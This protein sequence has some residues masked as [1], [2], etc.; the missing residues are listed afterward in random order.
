V[1]ELMHLY[2][3]RLFPTQ[4][5][6]KWLAYG[7]DSKHA[8][9]N[10]SFF[11]R[12]EFCFTLDGDIFVRYQ[13]FK[14]GTELQSAL[15]DRVPA[16]I[17]IGPVYNVDPAKR[18]AYS[19]L[20]S[21]RVFAPVE[22][23]LVFDI[24][25]TDYDDVRTCCSEGTVCSLCWPLMSIA[26]SVIHRG[27]TEDFGFKNVLWVFSGRRGVH[28]WVCDP[29]ARALTDSQRSAVASY[30]NVYKVRLKYFEL[31]KQRIIRSLHFPL[32]LSSYTRSPKYHT[33]GS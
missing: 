33:N 7:N 14:D 2:Y 25:M 21:D 12:R 27:L 10:G 18:T 5:I 19:G 15:K 8:Q 26:I 3:A 29:Q 11:Q 31:L 22:R 6:Y 1:Q 24:D 23:E 30:F 32:H 20:G 28:C 4:H 13:S 17:D 9:A 16:K